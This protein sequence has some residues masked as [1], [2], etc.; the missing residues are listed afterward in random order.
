MGAAARQLDPEVRPGRRQAQRPRR[1][2]PL[3]APPELL[4]DAR[5]LL[6]RRLLQ[7]RRDPVG[8][9]VGHRGAR[10][11]TPTASGSPSTSTTTRP[12]PSGS[13]Q[14]GFP[15]ERIVR[16]DKDNFWEMGDTGPCGPSSELF[17][18]FG[19]EHGPG[20]RPGQ[21]GGREPL[22][23]VLEPGVPA[24]LPPPRRLARPTCRRANIDTGAGLERMVGRHHR[25]G[26]RCSPPTSWPRSVGGGRAAHRPP[27]RRRTPSRTSRSSCSPTTPAP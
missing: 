15:A 17:W 23:R 27:P 10:A 16:F 4:R 8:L 2:R 14:V 18:D 20:R 22:R 9:G 24:V 11:S 5:Q 6:L 3:A 1:H 21:P 7:G 13:T 25:R 26:R 19:P 12:R